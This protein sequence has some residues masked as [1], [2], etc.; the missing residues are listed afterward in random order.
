ML[1]EKGEFYME[2]LEWYNN[3]NIKKKLTIHNKADRHRYSSKI[4]I[5]DPCK[6]IRY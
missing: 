6:S 4:F 2:P 5:K 1:N 3:I